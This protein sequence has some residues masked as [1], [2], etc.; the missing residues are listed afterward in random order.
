MNNLTIIIPCYNEIKNLDI[1]IGEIEKIISQNQSIYFILV[2][3]GSKDGTNKFLDLTL[4]DKKI[5]VLLLLRK[6]KDMVME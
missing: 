5:L 2:D 4:K 1:I 3:N 6:I